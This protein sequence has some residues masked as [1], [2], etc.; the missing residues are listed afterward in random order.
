MARTDGKTWARIVAHPGLL[1]LQTNGGNVIRSMIFDR[2][3]RSSKDQA[4]LLLRRE[5]ATLGYVLVED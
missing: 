1:E 3:S 4:L 5:A 2:R